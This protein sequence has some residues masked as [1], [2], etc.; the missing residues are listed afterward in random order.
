VRTNIGPSNGRAFLLDEMKSP[1]A[2]TTYRNQA[3]QRVL[4]VLDTFAGVDKPLSVA[5][6]VR[7]LG[8]SRN[9]IDRVLTVLG[10]E[11]YITRDKSG[12]LFQ[13]GPR[14]LSFASPETEDH[15]INALCRPYM[16]ML[17]ELTGESVFLMIIVGR[18][19]VTVDK[20]EGTGRRIAHSERGLAVPLHVGKASRVLLAHLSDSQIKSYLQTAKPLSE[21]RNLFTDTAGDSVDSVWDDIHAIRRD[22]YI[23]WRSPQQYGGSYL[24]FPVLDHEDRPHAVITIGAPIER[25]PPER[26]AELLPRIRQIMAQLQIRARLQPAAPILVTSPAA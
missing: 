24:A 16:E 11:G 6:L 10:D 13:L 17:H 9:M 3:A 26:V 8:M 12:K 7:M 20:I 19:R 1:A 25:F 18:N 4:I 5:E 14:I 15:D 22:G 23:A 2:K 21:F